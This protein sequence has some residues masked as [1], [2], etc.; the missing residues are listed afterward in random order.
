MK[1]FDY[2]HMLTLPSVYNKTVNCYLLELPTYYVLVDTGENNDDTKAFW[3]ELLPTLQKPIRY[4]VLTHIHT[5]H[6][7]CCAFLQEQLQCTV[8]ASVQ[9][10]KKLAVMQKS[11]KNTALLRASQ[12]YGYSYPYKKKLLLDE[13]EA[14]S[15]TID[16]TFTDGDVLT[17]HD[18]QLRAMLLQGHAIDQYCFYDD[19]ACIFIASDHLI[20]AFNP[21]L[22]IE[23]GHENPLAL[24]F[25]SLEKVQQLPDLR[26]AFSG[27]GAPIDDV[28]AR[29]TI[30]AQRHREKLQ[31]LEQLLKNEPRS[32]LALYE[33]FYKRP[34]DKPNAQLIQLLVYVRYLH[35]QGTITFEHSTLS[36]T[37]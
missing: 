20:A 25:A 19:T 29:V 3:L 11:P 35:M 1:T 15:F 28:T 34:F 17:F 37:L 18:V 33:A 7:G 31:Q 6:A 30:I 12:E 4:I 36:H 10:K 8:L 2:V 23:E 5:D 13:D 14:Y 24:Y 16:E 26:I 9:S 21:I 27:H 32:L 22:L